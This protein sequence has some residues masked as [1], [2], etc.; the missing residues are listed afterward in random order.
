MD[1]LGVYIHIPFCASKCSYC[2]FCSRA[3]AEKLMPDYHEALLGHIAES[4][5][6]F[7]QYYVDTVY[8][9]GGT[10][11][12]YGAKRICELLQELKYAASVLKESEITVEAN[13]DSMDRKSL[14][15]LRKEGVNRLSVGVQSASDDILRLM[16]RRHSFRQA[17]D[18]VKM[19][20]DAGFDNISLDLMYGLPSQNRKEWAE[21]LS[22]ALE[23]RPEHISCYGLKLEESTP[24]YAQFNGTPFLPDDDEQADMYLFAVETLGSYG[25]PQ[26]EIS[27]FAVPGYESR[28]NMKYWTLDDYMGFGASAHSKIGN[29]RYAYTSD[30]ESYIM[31]A[32][33]HE[34]IISEYEELP[35]SEQAA[36]Y[37]IFGM[38]TARGI[39]EAEFFN[40]YRGNFGALELCLRDFEKHGWARSFGGRWAFTPNGFLLSN[41]LINAL[42][43]ARRRSSPDGF[44]GEELAP[45]LRLELRDFN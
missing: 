22:R 25:Y 44:D 30:I 4:E 21:T 42:L 20:R 29:R 3:G 10:P 23:L 14:E 24:M 1:K 40:R 37:I 31:G 34:A 19:A 36:E 17:Q 27:N 2:D 26:Y 12:Y 9:G 13:P 35:L 45:R 18:A 15:A 41:T 32:L 6:Q 5:A 7:T 39:S 16:G 28:H 43:D 11:S 33:G 8:F 38:R